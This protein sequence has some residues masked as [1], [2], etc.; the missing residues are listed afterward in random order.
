MA[1]DYE[2]V[3]DLDSMDD[4]E[5]EELIRQ[6]FDEMPEID[7]EVVD[8]VVDHGFVELHGR[9]GTEQELQQIEQVVTDLLGVQ[10][11]RNNLVVDELRRAEADEGADDAAAEDE[12]IEDQLLGE[13]ARNTE[14]SAEHLVEDVRTQLYGTRDLQDAIQ[15]GESYNPPTR[16]IQEGVRGH[17]NH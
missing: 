16:P 8:V 6:Q 2:N 12:E 17:E 10:R 9:V 3:Y 11:Y 7:S 14:P 1:R 15:Q 4:S 13:D 5:I